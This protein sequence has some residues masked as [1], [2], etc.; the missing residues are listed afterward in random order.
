MSEFLHYLDI[1]QDFHLC[2]LCFFFSLHFFV[3]WI[4]QV[5]T[6][7]ALLSL[8]H[9][10]T[11]SWNL[12]FTLLLVAQSGKG[13]EDI[14]PQW[15]CLNQ[16]LQP[17]KPAFNGQLHRNPVPK[18]VPIHLHLKDAPNPPFKCVLLF[19]L[20]EPIKRMHHSYAGGFYAYM[21]IHWQLD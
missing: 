2:V 16:G 14:W 9:T 21:L 13:A 8:L 11:F 18:P 17:L 10:A 6:A 20:Y 1:R 5:A 7:I 4:L 12:C 15:L 19:S 3:E